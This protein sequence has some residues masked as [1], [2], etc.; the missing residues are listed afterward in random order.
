MILIVYKIS[1]NAD[2]LYNY[3][4]QYN[5]IKCLFQFKNYR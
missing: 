4:L 2:I 3:K 5:I 1:K